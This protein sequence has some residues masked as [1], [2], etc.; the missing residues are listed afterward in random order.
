MTLQCQHFQFAQPLLVH[1]W[2]HIAAGNQ[3]PEIFFYREANSQ[4]YQGLQFP[5]TDNM[6]FRKCFFLF[7]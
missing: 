3:L 6:T 7:I 1:A 4:D 2:L 5:A